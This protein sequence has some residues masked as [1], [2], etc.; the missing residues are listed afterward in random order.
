MYKSFLYK[1]MYKQ[2]YNWWLGQFLHPEHHI[3]PQNLRRLNNGNS[4]ANR[5]TLGGIARL[6]SFI[7]PRDKLY[8]VVTRHIYTR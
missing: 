4:N 6:P 1:Y 2:A 7:C 5:H 3:A 8:G